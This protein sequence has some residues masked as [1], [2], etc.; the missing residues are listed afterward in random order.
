LIENLFLYPHHFGAFNRIIIEIHKKGGTQMTNSLSARGKETEV[1]NMEKPSQNIEESYNLH[2]KM[3]YRVCFSYLK[4]TEDTKDAVSEI[5]LKL[6]K[7]KIIF[8]TAE[9]EKAWLLRTSI[10]FC[11]DFLKSRRRKAANIDDYSNIEGQNPFKE[12]EVLQAVMDLPEKY[13]YVVHLHYYEGYTSEEI[14]K[15]LKKP[16]STIRYHLQ[17][18]R[19]IL[20]GALENEE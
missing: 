8:Q 3:V 19:K 9:H 14:S 17:E 5:F 15:I 1:Q 4:N 12:N 7:N 6:I 13:K 10:N 20:K 16:H 18:A 2:K 11:K